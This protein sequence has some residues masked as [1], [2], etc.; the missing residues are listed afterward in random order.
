MRRL[1]PLL[2]ILA[3]LLLV[4]LAASQGALSIT[5]SSDKTEYPLG[6]TVNIFGKVADSQG[7]STLGVGV[8]I[9]VGD[10]PTFIEVVYPDSSGAYSVS[11]VLSASIAPGQY[12]VYAT[13]SKPG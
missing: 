3:G 11:F 2:V 9:Q 12:T 5:V 10:P 13:A 4:P 1:L 7:T 8:S 6:E